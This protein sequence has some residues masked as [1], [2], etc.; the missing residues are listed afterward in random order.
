LRTLQA[1]FQNAISRHQSGDVE[2]AMR[3]YRAIL[4]R[5]PDH[6]GA[7][8]LLGVTLHQ[9][10]DS[11]RAIAHLEKALSF[12]QTK[13]VYW[14]N[15]GAALRGVKRLDKAEIAFRRAL[16]L[17][18]DYPDALANAALSCL[19]RRSYGEAIQFL[20]RAVRLEP[21]RADAHTQLG[22]AFRAQGD[23]K[24]AETSYRRALQLASNDVRAWIGLASIA[25]ARRRHEK[26]EFAYRRALHLSPENAEIH[27][28]LGDSLAAQGRIAEGRACYHRACQLKPG[29]ELWSLR[30]LGTCPAIFPDR[31]S[32][33]RYRR[34]LERRLNQIAITP[35][36]FEWASCVGN[37][38]PPPFAL[39]HHGGCNRSVKE[40]F[41]QI[42]SPSF[43]HRRPEP[44]DAPRPRVGFFVTSHRELGFLRN[45]AHTIPALDRER[46]EAVVLCPTSGLGLCR[47]RIQAEHVQFVA[48]PHDFARAIETIRESAIDVLYHRQIGTDAFNYFLPFARC[49]PIQCTGWGT[50]G[51]TGLASVDYYLSST[52]IEIDGAD[53]HYT[54]QLHRFRDA[55]PTCPSRIRI[56]E[57][58]DREQFGLPASGAIYF[59]PQRIEKFHPDFDPLLKGVLE[60]DPRGCVV[61]LGADL[62]HM[63]K[64]LRDRW[65]RTIGEALLRRVHML[66][67]QHTPKYY[68]LLSL[69]DVV[70]DAPH[71]SASLTGFD[72][73]SFGVPIV[74]LPGV[75][76]VER[77][78]Q[79]LYRQMGIEE[80]TATNVEEYVALAVRLGT[81]SDYRRHWHE[82]ILR[83]SDILFESRTAIREFERFF[84][85][86][87]ERRDS[88]LESSSEKRDLAEDVRSS[89]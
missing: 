30:D 39:S 12:C 84:V 45:M 83:R 8:H 13:A 80:L 59:C 63:A 20:Q 17:K 75:Y 15:Y 4:K 65:S 9:R 49:A 2:S 74:T 43:P 34:K 40:R 81:D 3:L 77:Y 69:A 38:F 82:E 36:P 10:G 44:R 57:E 89:Q 6:A 33:A 23:F 78:A 56:P 47:R 53:D 70:L 51:T 31:D 58:G 48:Y 21:G 52:L 29:R 7:N 66:R 37:G 68:T 28:A 55:F 11:E 61:T 26:A 25:S 19:N 14:N 18:Q 1:T 50:H 46:V 32:L 60:S 62:T 42:F 87:W 67:R 79:G 85:N 16:A 88:L 73:F 54:E 5:H 71:Y 86:S 76:N 35:P 41:A 64:Q 27:L 22:D 72:A 24:Q